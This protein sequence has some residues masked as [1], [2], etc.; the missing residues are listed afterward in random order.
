MKRMKK[1]QGAFALVILLAVVI[2]FGWYTFGILSRTESQGKDSLKLGL[3]LA[4]GVSI[5]YEVVGKTPTKTQLDDTV[6]KLKNRI[7]NDLGKNAT[8]EANVYKVGS[9]RVAVEIPG[10]KDANALL[11]QLGTPGN[12]YFINQTDSKGNNNYILNKKGEYVLAQGKTIETLEKDGSIILSGSKVKTAKGGY[13]SDQSTGNNSPVVQLTLNK[14]GAKAFAD[15][16]K[17]AVGKTIGIYYDGKFVSVPKVNEPI[18]GGNCQITGMKNIEEAKQL[19]SYIR[20]GGLDIKIKELQ[21]EVVGAQLGTNAMAT[22]FL[23]AGVGLLIVIAFMII[24][25]YILGFAASI[26]L[27]LYTE[28][29][30]CILYWFGIT[31]TLPGIAGIILSIGMA[32][33]ANVII[34]SR[35]KEEIGFGK[36]VMSAITTGFSKAMSAIIDGN[37]TTLIA[38][39]VLGFIG[40]GTVKGFA[41][42]LAIGVVLSL[43]SAVTMTKLIVKSLYAV[44]IQNEKLY[45]KTVHDKNMKFINKTVIFLVLSLAII[46][47]GIG[48]MFYNQVKSGKPLSYSLEF[49]GGTATTVKMKKNYNV[50]QI[51]DEVVPVVRKAINSNDIQTQAVDQDSSIVIK[52]NTLSLKTRDKLNKALIEKFGVTQ[53]DISSKNISA[54]IGSEMRQNS[55]IAVLVSVFFMLIYIWLRFKDIRFGSSAIIAL[56]HDVLVTLTLYAVFRLSV[57]S[58]F[59]ACILTVIGYSINDTIVI[60]DRIRENLKDISK[61]KQSDYETLKELSDRS[62][63]EC[64]QRSISTSLTTAIMVL[65]LLVFGVASIREFAFP[66]LVG[67]VCGTYSSVCIATELWLMMHKRY[68]KKIA[69]NA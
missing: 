8:T 9:R 43:F 7:E 38:A 31:L 35:I 37:V 19:A 65:M 36:S 5:T 11:K 24:M 55:L 30:V 58:T 2:Y 60:F 56:A 42:T 25:Y 29:I 12:L 40:R 3:D 16:T 44:G 41:I 34:F 32:V 54:M 68:I 48:A 53:D 62:M 4:G 15:A 46:F 67:V 39:A 52:T 59:I 26:A 45:G 10:V 23:A 21:S 6:N 69:K 14:K 1:K 28:I 22:S 49:A 47:T 33:D 51:N 50:D 64:L 13:T 63:T 61:K 18:T 20:I 17:K 57:G 27:I 66:L